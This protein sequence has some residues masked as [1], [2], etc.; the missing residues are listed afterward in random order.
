MGG[1]ETGSVGS[2]DGYVFIP[3][4]GASSDS[5]PLADP[6]LFDGVPRAGDTQDEVVNGILG[7][8]TTKVAELAQHLK[9]VGGLV[10][11]GGRTRATPARVVAWY[12]TPAA[13]VGFAAFTGALAYNFFE[14]V[15]KWALGHSSENLNSKQI[16]ASPNDP[17]TNNANEVAIGAL[18]PADSQA[19]LDARANAH[20]KKD[21]QL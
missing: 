1:G 21:K 20:A 3:Q 16:E 14:S 8:L 5:I 7:A 15:A 18:D 9:G 6:N 2:S 10:G 4:D 13:V 11:G 17:T 19:Y 12:R